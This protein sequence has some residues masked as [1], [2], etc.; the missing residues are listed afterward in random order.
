MQQFLLKPL[1]SSKQKHSE[2]ST[3]SATPASCPSASRAHLPFRS[4]SAKEFP[5]GKT[6]PAT[7]LGR[8]LFQ[9]YKAKV[10]TNR[11]NVPT[12][13]NQSLLS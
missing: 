2:I 5:G 6:F 4:A 3:R 1:R 11:V 7:M 8:K 13:V 10:V 9:D 12:N